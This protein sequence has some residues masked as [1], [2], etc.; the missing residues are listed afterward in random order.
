MFANVEMKFDSFEYWQ[1]RLKNKDL[2]YGYY[3]DKTMLIIV[4]KQQ[5]DMRVFSYEAGELVKKFSQVVITGKNG[6][7]M[8]EGDLKTPVGVYDITK[9]FVPKDQFYG[10][11][12]F[13]LSYPNLLDRVARKTGGGI[14]IHGYPIDG[15]RDNDLTTRGC[16]AIKNTLLLEFGSVVD[17][18]AVV[19]ISEQIDTE[20]TNDEIALIF[21]SI[22]KW[23]NAWQSN[24]IKEYL[25]FYS[26]DFVSYNGEN[27]QKFKTTKERIFSKNEKKE[28]KFSN[29]SVTPY[30]NVK[31]LKIFRVIF[32]EEYSAPSHKF[33][34]KKELYVR[35]D[36]GKFKII[37]EN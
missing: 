11:L 28:I 22:F 30:P 15:K 27:F 32:D 23:Q 36:S 6:D 12:A 7:K 2:R 25:E 18:Q 13:S 35:L 4:N 16:V 24:D 31:D 8:R 34:G 33:K 19:L 10:P 21:S 37:A 29:F 17:N 20:S 3:T 9:R 5:K 14:W 1:N 26:I